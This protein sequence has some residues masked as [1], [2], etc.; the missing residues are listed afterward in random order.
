LYLDWIVLGVTTFRVFIRFV[1]GLRVGFF[2]DH[3]VGEGSDSSGSVEGLDRAA[4]H[5]AR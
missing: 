4:M 5:G 1:D 2:L 3:G